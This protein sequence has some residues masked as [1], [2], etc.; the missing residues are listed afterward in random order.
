MGGVSTVRRH[1]ADTVRY[2]GAHGSTVV[3]RMG[4]G[5]DSLR[6]HVAPMHRCFGGLLVPYWPAAQF[7]AAMFVVRV[8]TTAGSTDFPSFPGL[9]SS[10]E[11]SC[12]EVD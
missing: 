8:R 4:G 6:R 2:M 5:A 9:R 11:L 12:L 7:T 3:Y 10:W 1:M